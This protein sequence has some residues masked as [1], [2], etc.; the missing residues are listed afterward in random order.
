MPKKAPKQMKSV[1]YSQSIFPELQHNVQKVVDTDK[2]VK[3][4]DVFDKPKVGKVKKVKKT[5]V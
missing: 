3:E 5:K 1:N 4:S 2:K